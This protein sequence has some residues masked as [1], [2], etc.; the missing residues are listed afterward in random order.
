MPF[1]LTGWSPGPSRVTLSGGD[2]FPELLP[3]AAA[4]VPV[5]FQAWPAPGFT[6]E[7]GPIAGTCHR[8]L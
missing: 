8:A 5:S 2:A 1:S 3:V 7:D 6:L 4:P